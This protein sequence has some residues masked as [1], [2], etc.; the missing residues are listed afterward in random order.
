MFKVQGIL[1]NCVTNRMTIVDVTMFKEFYEGRINEWC[2]KITEGGVTGYE[3]F[4]ISSVDIELMSRRGW[5]ACAGTEDRWD[6]LFIPGHEMVKVFNELVQVK[7]VD[8]TEEDNSEGDE[9][10]AMWINNSHRR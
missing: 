10:E 2:I 8:S 3:S 5:W 6:G 1:T 9:N 7:F 4:V